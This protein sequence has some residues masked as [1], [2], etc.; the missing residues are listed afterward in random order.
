MKYRE[1]EFRLCFIMGTCGH[2]DSPTTGVDSIWI[3]LLQANTISDEQ[4][5]L[6]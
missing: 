6:R 5:Q 4:N 3:G 1:K 2:M